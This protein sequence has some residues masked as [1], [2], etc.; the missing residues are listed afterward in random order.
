VHGRALLAVSGDVV[1]RAGLTVALD[2]GA[3]LDLAVG[4]SFR[5][6]GQVTIGNTTR[7]AA[8]RIWMAGS[9][10]VVLDGGP[11][12][13]AAIHAPTANVSAGDG[14]ELFGALLAAGVTGDEIQIHYDRALL[15]GGETCGVAALPSP[16]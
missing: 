13:G 10:S 11:I 9:Q 4:G 2:A 6:S 3:E 8:V 16:N 15:A 7:P 5:S 14:F 12:V 1:L